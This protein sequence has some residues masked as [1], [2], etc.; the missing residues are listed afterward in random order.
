[1]PQVIIIQVKHP[2]GKSLGRML[3]WMVRRS[4]ATEQR[5]LSEVR[6]IMHEG[7]NFVATYVYGQFDYTLL[8][9]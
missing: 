1:M 3:G 2:R 4:V 6:R 9:L 8:F 7:Y 5:A